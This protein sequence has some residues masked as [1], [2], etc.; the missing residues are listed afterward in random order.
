MNIGLFT[1]YNTVMYFIYTLK[2]PFFEKYRNTQDPWPWEENPEEWSKLK[3]KTFKYLFINF[4]IVTP[5]MVYIS[6]L[7]S[8]PYEFSLEKWPKTT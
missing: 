3:K 7:T 1:V 4:F 2:I 6:L 8:L 5:L